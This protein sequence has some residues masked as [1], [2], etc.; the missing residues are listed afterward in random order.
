MKSYDLG[1]A[2]TYVRRWGMK[3]AIREL[4][5]NAIDSAA[6]FEYQFSQS[7]LSILSR[8]IT[9]SARHLLLGATSKA[10]VAEAIGSFGEGFKLAMLVLVRDGYT[11]RCNNGPLIWTPT[12][13]YHESFE[14]E[15]LR[16]D[17]TLG[18]EDGADLQFVI[19]GLTP[20]DIQ[21]IKESC[22]LMQEQI[23]DAKQ[24]SKGLIL[25]SRPGKLYVGGLFVCDTKLKYGYSVKPEYMDLERDRQ[26]VDN[27]SIQLVAKDMW[28]ETQEWELIAR[29]T[30]AEVP[31][32]EYS[33]YGAPQALRDT[34][35]KLFEKKHGGALI[36]RSE[37]EAKRLKAAGA[38]S[39]A[40]TGSSAFHSNVSSAGGYSSRTIYMEKL[41][42]PQEVLDEWFEKNK[43]Y[44]SRLP[45][46]RFKQLLEQA[47]CWKSEPYKQIKKCDGASDDVPF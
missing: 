31:D 28:F 38:K 41:K 8:G 15:C 46:T 27:F 23:L 14:E 11:V 25:P 26:T 24:T 5:Q 10:D 20:G 30:E 37:E 40:F 43:R 9:L 22:L 39:V 45:K 12:F 32:F 36:A 29:E 21:A 34:C 44:L 35:F 42:T 6:P 47:A 1:L 17:E 18:E 33:H 3:E 16:I 7:S 2:R 19:S 13:A 4:L